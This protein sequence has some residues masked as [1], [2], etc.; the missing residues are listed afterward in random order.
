[1]KSIIQGGVPQACSEVL[2][3]DISKNS[4]HASQPEDEAEKRAGA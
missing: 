4:V 2:G 1:V 3:G